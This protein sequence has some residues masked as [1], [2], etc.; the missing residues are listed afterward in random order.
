MAI[1]SSDSHFLP[2]S[3]CHH[4]RLYRKS[5]FR[6]LLLSLVLGWIWE[7]DEYG[8]CSQLL[9]KRMVSEAVQLMRVELE[10]R[11]PGGSECVLFVVPV[12]RLANSG[13]HRA[14]IILTV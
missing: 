4:P 10:K 5:W 8:G 11:G 13:D 6:R 2:I 14:I 1:P 7:W 3:L 12:G 9:A